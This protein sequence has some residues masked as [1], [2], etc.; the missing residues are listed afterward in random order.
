MGIGFYFPWNP[1][2]WLAHWLEFCMVSA[3]RVVEYWRIQS[4][5]GWGFVSV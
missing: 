2:V 4:N 5:K 3:W 1:I